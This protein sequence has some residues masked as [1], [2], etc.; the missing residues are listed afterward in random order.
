MAA[1]GILVYSEDID[2]D[3]IP[4]AKTIVLWRGDVLARGERKVTVPEDVPTEHLVRLD[5]LDTA[6]RKRAGGHGLDLA[7]SRMHPVLD[8]EINHVPGCLGILILAAYPFRLF[9]GYSFKHQF[10]NEVAA[11]LALGQTALDIVHNL[12]VSHALCKSCQAHAEQ[13]DRHSCK[14]KFHLSC[15]YNSNSFVV[16]YRAQFLANI[17]QFK[18]YS[19]LLQKQNTRWITR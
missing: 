18:H 5:L 13:A 9:F 7:G 14:S 11:A 19:L 15:W 3:F 4:G 10:L 2:Y 16:L 1:D 8:V 6:G 12:F 17:R